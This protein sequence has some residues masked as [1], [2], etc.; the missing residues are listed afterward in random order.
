[1]KYQPNPK[2]KNI[3]KKI[4]VGKTHEEE[5]NK[6]KKMQVRNEGLY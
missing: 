2:S 4:Q 6:S 1:M 5:K 3:P